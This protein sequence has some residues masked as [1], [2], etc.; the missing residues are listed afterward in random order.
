M[1]IFG[2]KYFGIDISDNAIKAME[3]SGSFSSAT[4]NSYG[5]LDLQTKIIKNGQVVNKKL[6]T[7]AIKQAIA[8][9]QPKKISTTSC[10]FALPESKLILTHVKISKK[11]QQENLNKEI[12]QKVQEIIP[13]QLKEIYY[14]YKTVLDYE[15]YYEILFAA[16]Q[17]D[18]L[19]DF[20]EVF[21]NANLDLEIVDF[22]SACMVRSLIGNC[23]MN[24]A[25]AIIDIGGRTTIISIYD[26]CN[27]RFTNNISI[28]GNTFTESIATKWDLSFQEAEEFK[29]SYG[30]DPV[31][32]EGKVML[33]LQKTIQELLAAVKK[34]INYYQ[35]KTGRKISKIILCGGSALMPKISDYLAKN[36]NITSEIG[37][38][39]T[40]IKSQQKITDKIFYATVA[41]LALR[42]LE[43]NPHKLGINLLKNIK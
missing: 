29:K 11:I 32:E 9:T 2:K 28:A 8:Q 21:K 15:D 37:N 41:G 10:L 43:K 35:D 13:F 5:N 14:D 20:I 33:V 39:F 24:D 26:Y 40:K 1:S 36:I 42:G 3:L 30:L 27:I 17:K 6:L 23:N 19:N 7:E 4:L 16:V 25:Y 18:I 38:P 34:D 31:A 22:E 12:L